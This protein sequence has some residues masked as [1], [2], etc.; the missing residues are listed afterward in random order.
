MNISRKYTPRILPLACFLAISLVLFKDAILSARVY[1]SLAHDEYGMLYAC[2]HYFVWCIKKGIFPFWNF[3]NHCGHPF[4]TD[5]F[6]N[7]NLLNILSIFFG[8][9][10]AW[11]I[12]RIIC[13]FF[14][15]YFTYL[16]AR[17]IKISKWGAFICGTTFMF[18]ST[19]VEGHMHSVSFFIP[20]IFICLEKGI[21]SMKNF[22]LILGSIFMAAY[23]LSSNPQFSLFVFIFFCGYLIFRYYS[24]SEKKDTK[25]ILSLIFIFF[26]LTVGWSLLHILRTFEVAKDSQRF[27]FRDRYTVLL[28]THIITA[29][30]PYFYESPFRGELNFFFGR[31]WEEF[32]KKIPVVLGQPYLVYMPYVGV[33]P[34]ILGISIFIK[35]TSQP[36][37]KFFGWAA[38]FVVIF[39]ST[40][41]LWHMFIRWIPFL[42]QM[43]NIQ[44][45]FIIYE[46][47]LAILAGMG[48]DYLLNNPLGMQKVIRYINKILMLTV[49]LLFLIF[50][51]IHIF[52]RYNKTLFINMGNEFINKY[53]I[54]NP[55]YIGPAKLYS[56][57]LEEIYQFFCSWTNVFGLSF[58]ISFAIIILCIF[59]LYRYVSGKC[60]RRLFK[61][62]IILLVLL[63]LF[64]I[65]LPRLTSVPKQMVIPNVAAAKFLQSQPGIFRVFHLQDKRDILK[66]MD[67]KT[68][69]RPNTNLFYGLSTFEGWQSLIMRRYVTY[70]KYFESGKEILD[71]FTG[72]FED[73][74]T[75]ILNLMNVK[76]VVTSLNRNLGEG[77]K[78]AYKDNKY[79]VY[80]NI[81]VLP[82]A[83]MV[84]NA[85]VIAQDDSI[86]PALKDPFFRIDKEIILEEANGK[87]NEPFLTPRAKARGIRQ[88]HT[89]RRTSYIHAING[90]DM[91]ARTYKFSDISSQVNIIK[92]MPQAVEVSVD[93]PESG[94]LFLSDCYYPAWKVFIDGKQDK[95]YRADYMFRAVKIPQGSHRVSFK[96]DEAAVR[97]G[98]LSIS[99]TIITSCVLLFKDFT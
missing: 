16:F 2:S 81:N 71:G 56:I 66:P 91:A 77:F 26:I 36:L 15:G 24:I 40:S 95:I 76:Y 85:R 86:L 18:T 70:I 52:I 67:P 87:T 90:V 98:L 17:T 63:D 41:F 22:W 89:E 6:S 19:N 51:I 14:S 54:G 34:F 57:R 83:F 23:Y 68:F 38:A 43:Y 74:D 48:F 99:L 28:P 45:T 20:L 11:T 88:S 44:R 5:P 42:Y 21:M 12:R 31:T 50:F 4:G 59:F 35:R 94:Y 61:I 58:F 1:I 3:M 75:K 25:R 13:V 65:A 29:I 53:V 30:M 79:R 92:Y 46:F 97:L 49:G 72:E 69:L 37:V 33:L 60:G 10:L 7:F 78:E 93:T 73:F 84:Y 82:R 47:S 39:M 9:T 96:Y 32:I 80:E 62:G 27:I 55:A 8:P 64:I